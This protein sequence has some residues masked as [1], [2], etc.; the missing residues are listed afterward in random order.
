VR[1]PD[2]LAHFDSK[3]Q[4]DHVFAGEAAPTTYLLAAFY[5]DN[6]IYVGMGARAF[7]RGIGTAPRSFDFH[8]NGMND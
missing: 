2:R 6:F 1:G 4:S 7:H 3:G 8:P 5:W